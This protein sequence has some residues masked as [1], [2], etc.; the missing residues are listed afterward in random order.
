M[1]PKITF[2]ELTSHWSRIYTNCIIPVMQMRNLSN[3]KVQHLGVPPKKALGHWDIFLKNGTELGKKGQIQN[4]NIDVTHYELLH[5]AIKN[6]VCRFEYAVSVCEM[7][8][9]TH[10]H[11]QWKSG[12]EMLLFFQRHMT[13][14]INISLTHLERSL[15][16]SGL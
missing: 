6:T 8:S 15:W 16:S 11:T 3:Q 14:V 7:G 13:S 10:T 9:H 5:Q 2:G 12:Q 1:K 4:H